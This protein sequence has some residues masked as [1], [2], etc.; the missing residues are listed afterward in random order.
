MSVVTDWLR[1]EKAWI[2]VS[3]SKCFIYVLILLAR[4]ETQKKILTD[5]ISVPVVNEKIFMKAQILSHTF[6]VVPK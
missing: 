4:K 2:R 5:I 1:V 3:D 6:S